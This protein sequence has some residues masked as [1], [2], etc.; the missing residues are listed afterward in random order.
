M[1]GN[2]DNEQFLLA[3]KLYSSYTIYSREQDLARNLNEL[4]DEEFLSAYSN[5][6]MRE[7]YNDVILKNYP[8]E[9]SIKAAFINE[10]LLKAKNQVVIFE[11]KVGSSRA[12]LCKI[13]GTS[14]AFEIKT[15]LD[16]T[17]RLEKQLSDYMDIFEH[18]F[19]IC[20]ETRYNAIK[21]KV[22]DDC[23]IYTYVQRNNGTYS[24]KLRKRSIL[25][26]QLDVQKQLSVLT[27]SDLVRYYKLDSEMDKKHMIAYVVSNYTNKKIND[28]FKK[29]LK[30][31]YKK[32]WFFL[33]CYRDNILEID[34][35]WF[36]KNRISPELMYGGR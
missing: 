33:S 1:S 36:F 11:L 18:V 25:D 19:V 5:Y 2:L 10:V 22:G 35:Q 27:K 14:T 7:I 20:S 15:D 23:G 28:V 21:D 3:Q 24:F 30:D 6:S 31:K 17:N 29:A 4:F 9:A 32:K 26:M 16:T 8:N 34:Y 12:D 13:N